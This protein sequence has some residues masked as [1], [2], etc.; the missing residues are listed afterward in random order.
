MNYSFISIN[1]ELGIFYLDKKGKTN[2]KLKMNTMAGKYL[3]PKGKEIIEAAKA[4]AQAH[5]K[6]SGKKY[7]KS[8]AQ[9]S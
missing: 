6:G 9:A 8:N 4:F 7:R 2:K 5:P 3:T 1:S